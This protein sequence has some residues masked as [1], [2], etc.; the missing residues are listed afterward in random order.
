MAA[1]RLQAFISP[2][3]T[4]APPD[5]R[6]RASM[7]SAPYKSRK[8]QRAEPA[9][10]EGASQPIAKR[11]K[12]ERDSERRASAAVRWKSWIEGRFHPAQPVVPVVPV[13]L[14]VQGVD[15][16]IDPT[17]KSLLLTRE[18]LVAAPSTQ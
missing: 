2:P 10:V 16:P 18:L 9:Q 3:P 12:A 7:P 4:F 5:S 6:L 8:R 1:S 11:Q 13:V 14:T 17:L 15:V